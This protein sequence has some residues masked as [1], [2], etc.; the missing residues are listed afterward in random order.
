MG[1]KRRVLNSSKFA[2]LRKHPKYKGLVRANSKNSEI[3]EE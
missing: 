3:Q 2:A 1:K